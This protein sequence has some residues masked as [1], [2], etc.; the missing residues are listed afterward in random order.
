MKYRNQLPYLNNVP[1]L[2]DGGLET[3]LIFQQ[4]VELPLFSS[5]P[6]LDREGGEEMLRD[7][8]R[9]YASIA[10]RHEMALILDSPT[11]RANPDWGAQLGYDQAAL[12]A[13][14]RRSIE[15]MRSIQEEHENDGSPMLVSG[16][17][18]PRGDGYVVS[19]AMTPE[20]AEAYHRPQV[21][22]FADAGA[23]QVAALTLNYVAEAIGIVRAAEKEEIPVVISF[24]VETDGRLPGGG[25]L[26]EAIRRCDEATGS[27]PARYLVNC[28]HPSHFG[29]VLAEGG[30]W[31]ERFGGFRANASR[32]SH[33]EL[34][35]CEE[36][37]EGDPIALG[38]EVRELLEKAPNLSIF[39]GCCGT[40]HRHIESFAR[41]V[42]P[43]PA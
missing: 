37:D 16:C 7:Y 36:L 25:S 22:A 13:I 28:A 29:T 39:G 31:L 34:D 30:E 41:Q 32:L 1:T 17:A 6:L 11:W 33:A 5:F 12:N 27:Y 18:G 38:T 10:R 23:D 9:P 21:S 8:F 35:E 42:A 20:E 26:G 3:V 4:G 24:T 14:N 43:L 19:G 2:T 40:D 15:L